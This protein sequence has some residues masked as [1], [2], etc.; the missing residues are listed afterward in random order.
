M[1]EISPALSLTPDEFLETLPKEVRC[2][3][4]KM[5]LE[6]RI[7]ARRLPSSLL[8]DKSSLLTSKMRQSI[9]DKAASLV[10]ENLT[11][12]ADM[13]TQFAQLISRTL[14]EVKIPCR[15]VMGN[16]IYYANGE[17]VFSWDHAWVRAGEEVID[18]NVDSLDENPLVP[19]SVRINP[20][21]GPVSDVP[22]DR[23]LRENSG[24]QCPIDPDVESIWWPEMREWVESL[25]EA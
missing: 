17:K 19:T 3:V 13:C 18:A 7:G 2:L 21:W 6:K 11:G 22:N 1:R 20:Y 12:R 10:D 8:I 5:R 9:L 4:A 25:G 23:R 15:V 16:A 24:I 14:L